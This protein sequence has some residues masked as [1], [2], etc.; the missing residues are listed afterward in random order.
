MSLP[1][2]AVTP[3]MPLEGPVTPASMRAWVH[4][5]AG[6]ARSRAHA[7]ADALTRANRT[8]LAVAERL[9]VLEIVRGAALHALMDLDMHL[10]SAPQPLSV[11]DRSML[12]LARKLAND[13]STG[14]QLALAQWPTA[15]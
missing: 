10:A 13:M 12:F 3:K 6:D 9:E 8:T 5:L 15:P 11:D 4:R 7:L 1:G 14:Y 2:H